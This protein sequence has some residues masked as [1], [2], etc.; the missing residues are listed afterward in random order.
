MCL[1]GASTLSGACALETAK[2]PTRRQARTEAIQSNQRERDAAPESERPV[3][4][5]R[6]A[7][8]PDGPRLDRLAKK[9]GAKAVPLEHVQSIRRFFARLDV[10]D[11]HIQTLERM[12]LDIARLEAE[13]RRGE[14]RN[15]KTLEKQRLFRQRAALEAE[16]ARASVRVLHLGDS[17]IAADYITRTVRA[18]LQ[19]RFGDGGRGFVSAEQ[20]SLYGGRRE[21]RK[22][23]NRVRAVDLEEPQ[24]EAL[25]LTASKLVSAR[26]GAEAVFS[27][28]EEDRLVFVHHRVFAGGPDLS[29]SAEGFELADVRTHAIR[30]EVRAL[31]VDVDLPPPAPDFLSVVAGDE[32]AEL[33]GLSFETGRAGA[34]YDAVG[35]VGADARVWSTLGQDSFLEQLA[36]LA[37]DLVVVMVGGNDALAVRQG[38]RT[39]REVERDL[40]ALIGRIKQASADVD[41]LVFG[42]MDAAERDGGQLSTK[43]FIPEVAAIERRV[44]ERMGCAHWDALA[45]MGGKDSFGDWLAEG[46]VNRDLIH[47]RSRGGDLLGH[48]FATAIMDAYLRGD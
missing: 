38:R 44:A 1:S 15:A 33:L 14:N 5:R 20:K 13:I 42:P 2:K 34:L 11:Q 9:V 25:G 37:P 17:H 19:A 32:G 41:C 45:A 6:A 35:P 7:P 47:P 30:P 16:A 31:R 8:D 12:D 43:E 40:T 26:S 3:E 36:A 29:V 24:R 21:T 4:R 23:W 28:E 10:L 18:R 39:L 27:L 46:L 22:G 48:L